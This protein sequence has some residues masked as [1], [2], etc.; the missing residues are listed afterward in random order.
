MAD[1]VVKAAKSPY[2]LLRS[3]VFTVNVMRRMLA[4]DILTSMATGGQASP[5]QARR[6]RQKFAKEK[7]PRLQHRLLIWWE[8]EVKT[9]TV[10]LRKIF[11]I[12][13]CSAL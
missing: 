13:S 3:Q 12:C 2:A 10:H 7:R 9:V 1:A 4:E 11:K 5:E 8:Q 6:V